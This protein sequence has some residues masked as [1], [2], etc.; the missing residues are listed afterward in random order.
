MNPQTALQEFRNRIGQADTILESMQPSEGVRQMLLFYEEVRS[1]GCD[2]ESD[3]DM[4][5][6]Q[7]GTYNWGEGRFFEFDITRQFIT[8][9]DDED[10]VT[11]QLRFTFFFEPCP[12]LEDLQPGNKWCY[13]PRDLME[14]EAFIKDSSAYRTVPKLNTHHVEVTYSEV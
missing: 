6:F 4:L 12:A 1:D 13:N 3:G 7:W 11:S 14:F 9:T 5:L 10:Y 2:L 8:F